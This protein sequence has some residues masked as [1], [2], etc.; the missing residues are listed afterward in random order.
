MVAYVRVSTKNQRL[1]VQKEEIVKYCKY[2]DIDIIRWYEDKGVSGALHRIKWQ[3]ALKHAIDNDE[4]DGVIVYDLSRAGRSTGELLFNLEKLRKA[5]KKFISVKE[6]INTDTKEGRFM[7]NVLAAI[8]ELEREVIR[9]RMAA[10][11][12][13]AKKYGTKSGKPCHRPLKEI[14]WELVRKFRKMGGSWRLIAKIVGVHP[15]T[16]IRRAG[17]EAPDLFE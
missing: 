6:N 4:V 9:E 15:N 8:A 3:R 7:L 14:D 1:D 10:G 5:G 2:K 11:R 13:Y 17:R 16:L 12:E